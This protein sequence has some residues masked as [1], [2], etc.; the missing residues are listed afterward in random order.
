VLLHQDG[1]ALIIAIAFL[2]VLLLAAIGLIWVD[3]HA[4][5][6]NLDAYHAQKR[7]YARRLSRHRDRQAARHDD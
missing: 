1:A 6:G 3:W 2:L 5:N 4:M 7:Y